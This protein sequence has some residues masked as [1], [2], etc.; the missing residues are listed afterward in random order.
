MEAL[1]PLLLNAPPLAVLGWLYWRFAGNPSAR[2]VDVAALVLACAGAI[3]CSML[4][5][6]LAS[7]HAGAIWKHVAAAVAAYGGFNVVLLADLARR[8]WSR[9][10]RA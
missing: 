8:Q 10:H 3:A 2:R 9:R 7:G 5:F 1:V 4:A 6:H